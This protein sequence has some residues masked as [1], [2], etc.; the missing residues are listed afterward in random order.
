[1]PWTLRQTRYLLSSGSP[2]SAVQKENM[3]KELHANPALGHM[4]K[5]SSRMA[6]AFKKARRG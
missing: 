4:K 5:G 3:H 2:L 1:V 6:R